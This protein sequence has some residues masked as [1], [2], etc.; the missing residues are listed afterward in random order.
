VVCKSVKD[1]NLLSDRLQ[2]SWTLSGFLSVSICFNSTIILWSVKF[3][4]I[5][6][7]GIFLDT[8]TMCLCD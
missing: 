7:A 8:F 5:G 3:N 4:S 6:P 1:W 2:K